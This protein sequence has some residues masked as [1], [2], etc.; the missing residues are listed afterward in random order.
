MKTTSGRLD[1]NGAHGC[2]VIQNALSVTAAVA[3]VLVL[4]VTVGVSAV[5]DGSHG[6]LAGGLSDVTGSIAITRA[7]GELVR[8]GA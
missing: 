2:R 3:V 5:V 7:L 6:H 8:S 4:L 1:T